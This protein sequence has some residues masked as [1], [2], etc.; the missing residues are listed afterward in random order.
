DGSSAGTSLVRDVRAGA[1]GSAISD[2]AVHA[3]RLYFVADDGNTG[4]ELWV[5]DGQASGTRLVTD[6]ATGASGSFPAP[7][8]STPDRLYFTAGT[9]GT[10][11]ELW[12]TDGSAQG[13]SLVADLRPGSASA[14]PAQLRAVGGRLF[15]SAD[16]PV[17]GRELRV[18]NAAGNA[19]LLLADLTPGTASTTFVDPVPFGSSLLVSVYN[20]ANT[21]QPLLINADGVIN[22]PLPAQNSQLVRNA[23]RFS[24]TENAVFF[25][26]TSDS[27]A[28]ELYHLRNTTP[29]LDA[30]AQRQIPEDAAEQSVSLS[31]IAAGGGESQFLR[32][33]ATSS[34][35]IL[36]PNPTI[37]YTSPGTS[38]TLRFQPTA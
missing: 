21:G 27:H 19:V 23:S 16:D 36:I 25:S 31:G 33:T 24:G 34:N 4:A 37:S 2:L 35:T 38:G 8:T 15:F 29:Q 30:L 12:S 13:T 1:L 26:G 22:V 14:S 28:T 10:G 6:L 5:S 20:Q 18:T 3:N 32:V 17:H 7:L 11:T 9:P